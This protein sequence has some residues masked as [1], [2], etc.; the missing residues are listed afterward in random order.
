[1][2][3]SA[4]GHHRSDGTIERGGAAMTTEEAVTGLYRQLIDGWNAADAEAMA[5]ALA[6]DGLV[7]GFDGSQML[8]RDEVAAE[9]GAVFADHDTIPYVTKVRSVKELG[10][11]AALLHA[12]AG[13]PAG[14]D[15]EIMPDR[16][17]VQTVVARRS[18]DGW[19]VALFQ[20]TPARFDTRPD[21]AEALTAELAELVG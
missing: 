21:L 9:I 17:A 12:V 6:P 3:D 20:T 2:S 1:M 11:D 4:S 14:D 19:S 18:D 7:I 8:G 16:N 10:A 15:Q 5:A 13:M